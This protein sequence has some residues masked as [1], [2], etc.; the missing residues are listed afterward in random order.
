MVDS[1]TESPT[2]RAAD[3]RTRIAIL[4]GGL[5]SMAAAL[6]L[7]STPELRAKYDVTVY[8]VGWRI[9]GKGAS[10]R[11]AAAANRIEEHGLHIWLGF[12]ENAFRM[13]RSVYDEWTPSSGCP[14]AYW[15]DAF[16]PHDTVTFM[17]Q[18]AE[19]W[20]PW[21]RT[22]PRS[23]QTPGDGGPID[24]V[25]SHLIV[26]ME[27]M[28][29]AVLASP[30]RDAL[31]LRNEPLHARLLAALRDLVEGVEVVADVA[32][33]QL[34]NHLIDAA[35]SGPDQHPRVVSA[36]TDFRAHAT[37][38]LASRLDTDAAARHLYIQ[39]DLGCTLVCGVLA[40][41]V[42]SLADF[43]KLDA[44][45][46]R[47]WLAQHGA[48]PRTID[49]G[50]IRAWYDLGFSYAGG[51]TS[52]PMAAAGTA[53]RAMIRMAAG[54]KGAVM[55]KMQAG[56][57]D[58]VFTPLYEVL[59]K[60]GVTFKFFHRV[61]RLHVDA[62]TRQITSIDVAE[63]VMVRDGAAYDPFVE[64]GGLKCWPSEPLYDQ[65]QQGEALRG[66]GA[67]LES[68]WTTWAD[69]GRH[70]L[71]AGRD[72]DTVVLGIS[73][74]ALS[75]ICG[76]LIAIDANWQ[77]MIANIP[78]VRTQA[79]QVW[80]GPNARGLGWPSVHTILAGYVEPV[81]T[82]GDLSHL[83]PREQ[84]PAG[85]V[86]GS[87]AYLCGPLAGTDANPPR[88]DAGYPAREAESVRK[89]AIDWLSGNAGE[90]W[91]RAARDGDFEW[92]L[93]VDP[94]SRDGD[95]R[96]EAQYWRANVD[97]S[98]RYVQTP[99]LSIR[100]RLEPGESGFSNL[101]L[102]GDWVFTG[103]NGGCVEAAV[104]GGMK[105]ARAICGSPADIP[106]DVRKGTS[107]LP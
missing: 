90:L 92:A 101:Y 13:I 105:A 48:S 23:P 61:D 29:D 14:F 93:L 54:Y 6:E 2:L 20:Q 25:W 32:A 5:G 81:A 62:A 99:P 89:A 77:A 65:L 72:F 16:K 79:F 26:I 70:T 38:A 30:V 15:T 39:L 80:L 33:H 55:W 84:W 9:G 18:T 91:P 51:D 95:A 88:D 94:A 50:P 104:M 4:G 44:L 45:E 68:H 11:N 98:E 64:V 74:G 21:T 8:Q 86:P 46:L 31:H 22:L 60:R 19:G 28:R 41:G 76:E 85:E 10:G 58:T 106:G 17:E 83:V 78:T 24:S 12:Y 56:M 71:L 40:G 59:T 63:Q 87:I 43:N 37:S 73:L 52:Q 57:G 67:D 49:S 1:A 36:L 100:Y 96:F 34:L 35:R 103:I 3:G 27:G 53:L 107:P 97:P 7:T 102:A 75:E 82:W 47:D 66:S 69:A 42:W